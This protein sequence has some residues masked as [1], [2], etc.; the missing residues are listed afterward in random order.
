MFYYVND[1]TVDV[2]VCFDGE[3]HLY[4]DFLLKAHRAVEFDNLLASR[5]NIS[6][7]TELIQPYSQYDFTEYEPVYIT[8]IYSP[9]YTL[10]TQNPTSIVEGLVTT[11]VSITAGSLT[12]TAQP[13]VTN[14]RSSVLINAVSTLYSSQFINTK[15][16]RNVIASVSNLVY[17][18]Q[19]ITTKSNLNIIVAPRSNQYIPQAINTNSVKLSSVSPVTVNYAA[20]TINV[21][22]NFTT[23]I[24]VAT[25]AYQGQSIATVVTGATSPNLPYDNIGIDITLGL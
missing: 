4:Q 6:A 9:F 8:A 11:V 7:G 10:E 14:A 1:G 20:Q 24:L 16:N 13:I 3:E 25:I 5:P 22:K 21:K 17:S 15:A 23:T 2:S 19:S 12:Y 18:G